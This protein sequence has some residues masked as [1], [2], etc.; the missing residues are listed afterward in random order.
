MALES[1]A[2]TAAAGAM[3]LALSTTYL[4]WRTRTRLAAARDD[5]KVSLGV[6]NT[7][8]SELDAA[9]SAFEEAF[10]AVEGDQVRLVW[11]EETL[12]SC[13]EALGLRPNEPQ[14]APQVVKALG[15]TSPEAAAGLKALIAEGRSC[16][17]EVFAEK[18]PHLVAAT[19]PGVTL[20][21][22]GKSSG[23]TAWIRLAIAGTRASLSTG[24]FAQMPSTCRRRAGSAPATAASSGQCG[25]AEGRRSLRPRYAVKQNLSLDAGADALAHEALEHKVRREGFRW[26]T[27]AG[28]RRA[29]QVIAEPLGRRLCLRLCARC[30]RSRGQSR[31]PEAPRQGAR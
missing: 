18:G 4:A 12:K 17:F 24:P 5:L 31:G 19:P 23:A 11:G 3:A 8:L 28:Q 7:M 20:V 6:K 13:A 14:F 15:D 21:L 26:L 2:Y 27:I 22:E 30:H 9:T 16:R 29:F 1:I 10:L 25:V